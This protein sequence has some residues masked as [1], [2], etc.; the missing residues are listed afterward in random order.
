MMEHHRTSWNINELGKP[1]F[2]AWR[3]SGSWVPECL[4]CISWKIEQLINHKKLIFD[5]YIYIIIYIYTKVFAQ[6]CVFLPPEQRGLAEECGKQDLGATPSPQQLLHLKFL[7]QVQG[8]QPLQGKTVISAISGSLFREKTHFSQ[9]RGIFVCH[10][11]RADGWVWELGSVCRLPCGQILPS[12]YGKWLNKMGHQ[13]G[14]CL[15][16]EFGLYGLC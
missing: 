2:W 7:S 9:R 4:C 14:S 16:Q 15:C 10:G 3:S 6:V 8:D 13:E 5:I 1:R 11:P 12:L